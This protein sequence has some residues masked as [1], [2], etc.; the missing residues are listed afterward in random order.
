MANLPQEKKIALWGHSLEAAIAFVCSNAE[1]EP[2]TDDVI[3]IAT[4]LFKYGTNLVRESY[5]TN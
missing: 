4:L 3:D 1:K 5:N 2:T